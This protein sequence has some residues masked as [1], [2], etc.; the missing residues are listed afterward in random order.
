MTKADGKGCLISFEGGEGAG[1]TEQSKE[2]EKRLQARG[3]NVLR[4]REP[5]GTV[6]SEQIREVVLSTK[7]EKMAVE[8]EVLLMQAQRAQIYAEL[9]CPALE[10]GKIVLMD[11]TRDSSVVYQGIVR[12]VG[13]KLV[14]SLNDIS[15]RKTKPD[16]TILLDIDPKMGLKRRVEAYEL[17]RIELENHGFHNKVRQA[18]LKL[19][20]ENNGGRWQVINAEEKFEIVAEKI[21]E[22]VAKELGVTD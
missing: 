5:G 17:D 7:N 20:R 11:R 18:Y 2:L 10:K 19:A 21:W 9:V 3:L 1:K 14:E 22:L 6:I 8:T 16:L 15:T 4:A 13:V 12:G